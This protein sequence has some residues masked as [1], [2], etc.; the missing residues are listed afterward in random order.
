MAAL[1]TACGTPPFH[2]DVLS[3]T[4]N[5]PILLTP[6]TKGTSND[7]IRIPLPDFELDSSTPTLLS[8]KTGQA[9]V[10]LSL[11]MSFG[12]LYAHV[13]QQSFEPLASTAALPVALYEALENNVTGPVPKLRKEGGVD[14]RLALAMSLAE[15]LPRHNSRAWGDAYNYAPEVQALALVPG[16]RLRLETMLPVTADE[17]RSPD[18]RSQGSI[19]PPSYLSVLPAENGASVVLAPT[20]EKLSFRSDDTCTYDDECKK[21]RD[22]SGVHNLLGSGN[23]RLRFWSLF[24]PARLGNVSHP[25]GSL[26]F[27]NEE[28]M[29][30]SDD[31]LPAVLLVGTSNAQDMSTFIVAA[32][33]KREILNPLLDTWKKAVKER[34]AAAIAAKLKW[35]Q[36]VKLADDVELPRSQEQSGAVAALMRE[37]H[38]H[39]ELIRVSDKVGIDCN[40]TKD[41]VAKCFILRYRVLPV[42]E[43][44]VTVQGVPVWV[45]IGTTVGMALASHES[46]RT[47]A[48]F[49][50]SKYSEGDE[51]R[52]R[53]SR[54]PLGQIE[55][56]RMHMGARS[57]VLVQPNVE[58]PDE[59]IRRIT[60]QPGDEIKWSN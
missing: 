60:L 9:I 1:V 54:I 56:S 24:Y 13:S 51:W 15:R 53:Q 6:G 26:Q 35:D 41:I 40:I 17:S 7:L 23:A 19:M 3:G 47:T 58:R 14:A 49:A 8:V 31:G 12:M 39:S 55:F 29:P 22:A 20:L 43:I 59:A 18:R 37:R 30:N 38:A 28:R 4:S 52:N 34:E 32:K 45:E 21:W 11:K 25:T 33:A 10:V 16:M 57:R 2:I 46:I 44:L 48:S 36:L 42:P 27:V 5:D 50:G